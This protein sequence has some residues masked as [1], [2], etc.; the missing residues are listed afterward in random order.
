MSKEG[1]G[2]KEVFQRVANKRDIKEGSLMGVELEG[3]KI[4][5]AMIDGQVFAIDAVCSHKGAHLEQGKLEGY[6]LT[7]PW[8]YAVFDVR[9]G[10]VSDRTV[11][12]KNQT[13][14]PVNVDESTGDILI[15]VA[16]GIRQNGGKEATDDT[17]TT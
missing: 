13:S 1:G 3:N 6:N 17:T 9:N 16:A 10:K 8:H 7:C 11:W 14:Y 15:N 2:G 5:L 4:A 12:A